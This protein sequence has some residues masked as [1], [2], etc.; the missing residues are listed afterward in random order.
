MALHPVLVAAD[1]VDLAIMGEAAERL[2]QPPL[3]EGVGGIA[4]VEDRDP[5]LEPLVQ[6]VRVEEAEALR[7]EQPL[8][9]DRPARQRTDVEALDLRR[10]HR[11]LD[12]PADEVQIL[13]EL[14]GGLLVGQR[15]G[16]HDLL[17]LGPRRLRLLAD[18]RDVDRHLPPAIDGIAGL[19][20]FGFDDRAA[21]LLRGQVGAR[22]EDHADRQPVRQHLVP[23]RLDRLVE[24]I[25]VDAG[26]VA[27]LAV[28]ID[29]T[30]VPHRLQRLDRRS[31]HAARGVAVR[32]RDQ[33]DATCIGLMVRPV[34][35]VLG[36]I[37]ALRVP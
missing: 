1:R 7:Q 36:E 11:L 23:G 30:P 12:P 29:R 10:D 21:R 25:E 5:A 3:R 17:D 4:L 18:H 27:R 20:H 14:F 28:G 15:P 16:D 2:S 9:D 33:P 13:L 6:Q 37:G 26:P 35:A 34:H 31:D 32:R 22:Q 24:E 19:D 8:V